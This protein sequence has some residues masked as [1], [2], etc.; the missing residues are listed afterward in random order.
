V[1]WRPGRLDVAGALL[2]TAGAQAEVW[3]GVIVGGPRP[4]VAALLAVGTLAT[5]WA[6]RAPAVVAPVVLGTTSLGPALLGVDS[7]SGLVWFLATIVA[8]VAA[9]YSARR[10]LLSLAAA[11]AIVLVAVLVENGPSAPDVAYAWLLCGGCWAAGRMVA[12]RTQRA[13]L[14]EERAELA[15]REGRWRG[16]AAVAE[17]RL[18]IA[19]ELHDVVAHGLSVMTLQ[20]GAVRRLLTAEQ[21]D[22]R[23][24]LERVERTGRESMDEMRR[25]LGV[26]R[27]PAAGPV[28]AEPAPVLARLPELLDTARAAGLV[29]TSTV[30]G[31]ARDLPAG[32]ELAAFRILQEAVTNALRHA[33]AHHLDCTVDYA[34][35]GLGL[36]VTDD[37]RGRPRGGAG[38]GHGVA[39]MRER[40][41]LY[42]GTLEA[43]PRPGGGF[44]VR[45]LLPVPAAG[46]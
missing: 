43:G 17:E 7:N 46:P 5:A 9:G 31:T 12:A 44:T 8:L 11:L 4:A 23:A 15:E 30:R 13:R 41:G 34:A 16:A 37:G 25:L 21:G 26:L 35:D 19:R 3:T 39:G 36:T 45:A 40:A 42:G 38:P 14:S 28:G 27:D 29:V 22:E 10:P 18:R 24:A 32:V 20:V 6:R 2:L 33:A 1:R